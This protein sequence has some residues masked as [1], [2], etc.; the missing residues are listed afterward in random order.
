MRHLDCVGETVPCVPRFLPLVEMASRG[1][2]YPKQ[3]W[4][5]AIIERRDKDSCVVNCMWEQAGRMN[6]YIEAAC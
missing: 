1:S 3:Q 6:M 4:Q 2:R 5:C